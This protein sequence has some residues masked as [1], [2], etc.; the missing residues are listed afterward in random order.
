MSRD[1]VRSAGSG[2]LEIQLEN[3][4]Q[5]VL[6]ATE[7]ESIKSRREGGSVIHMKSARRPILI[8]V[9]IGAVIEALK[10]GRHATA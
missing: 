2:L 10:G 3:G 6:P 4:W 8:D 1:A 7:I 9:P 5:A